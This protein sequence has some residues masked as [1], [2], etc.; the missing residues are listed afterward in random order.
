MMLHRNKLAGKTC[1]P[2]TVVPTDVFDVRASR[3][4]GYATETGPSS[5]S[6]AT[7][8]TPSSTAKGTP[9]PSI[10]Y[11][12]GQGAGDDDRQIV[13]SA[14]RHSKDSMHA[15]RRHTTRKASDH[16][17]SI[18]KVIKDVVIKNFK[19]MHCRLIC[20]PCVRVSI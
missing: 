1:A 2:T 11:L 15:C 14:T 6:A 3:I 8:S 4:T 13:L 17:I 7:L 16:T 20:D 9:K 10:K 19:H 5:R 18:G 12:A